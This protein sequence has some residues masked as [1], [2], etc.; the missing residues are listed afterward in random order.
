MGFLSVM[1]SN[2]TL[3]GQRVCVKSFNAARVVQF[4]KPSMARTLF[5][6]LKLTLYSFAAAYVLTSYAAQ[7]KI[8]NL[9]GG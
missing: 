8:T 1:Q 7:C 2:L 6:L 9:D 3:I 5:F 4:P